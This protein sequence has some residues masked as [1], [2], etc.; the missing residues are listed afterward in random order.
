MRPFCHAFFLALALLASC[1]MASSSAGS[2]DW[3]SAIVIRV[4]QSGKG[5]FTKIQDAIDAVPSRNT[6]PIFIRIKPGI[7]REKIV[8]PADKPFIT[9]SGTKAKS[10]IITW[11]EGWNT[12]ESPTVSVLAS[13]FVGRYLTIQNTFGSSGQAIALRVAGDRVAF[14]GC[15]FFSFQDTLLDD[16]GRHYYRN[17]YIEGATDFIC[18]NGQALFEK[19]HLHSVSKNGGAITAQRR[20]S[21]SENTGYSFVGCKVTGVGVGTTVLGRPWGAYS[22]VVFALTYMTDSV[23]AQGWND[24]GDPNKQR[25]AFYGQYR[26]Y[27]PGS[28]LSR[29]VGWSRQLSVREASHFITKSWINGRDWL[30]SPPTHFRKFSALTVRSSNGSG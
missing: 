19:C 20:D 16:T 29:R 22:R 12:V 14:Y 24:W 13:D 25:T 9:L 27:G 26:C 8:V 23:A 7:Y 18:G 4:D 17:C 11:N 6:D 10:T 1:S 30:R 21:P 3:S 15:R 28:D 2:Q 5:D